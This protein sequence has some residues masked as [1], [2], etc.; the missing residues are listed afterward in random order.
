MTKALTINHVVGLFAMVHNP[1]INKYIFIRQDIQGFIECLLEAENKRMSTLWARLN[2]L[3]H[4]WH[5]DFGYHNRKGGKEGQK[6][7][8]KMRGPNDPL[9]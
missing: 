3:L 9:A 4:K 1:Q 8:I 5:V 6:S 2:F 7:K